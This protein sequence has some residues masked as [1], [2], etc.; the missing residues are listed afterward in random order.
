VV[1]FIVSRTFKALPKNSINYFKTFNLN[2]YE[3][4]NVLLTERIIARWKYAKSEKIAKLITCYGG[5]PK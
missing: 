5:A 3:I 4:D 2:F 1:N